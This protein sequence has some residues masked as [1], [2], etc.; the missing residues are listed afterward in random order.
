MNPPARVETIQAIDVVRFGGPGARKDVIANGG[1][2]S[3]H[4]RHEAPPLNGPE[5]RSL[6]LEQF[7]ESRHEIDGFGQ[8]SVASSGYLRDVDHQRDA[9]LLV[10]HLGPVSEVQRPIL[11]WPAG[12]ALGVIGAVD[13]PAGPEYDSLSGELVLHFSNRFFR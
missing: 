5:W 11:G 7:E 1:V 10:V 2:S 8:I 6:D 13:V 12:D 3:Q 9:S 4:R